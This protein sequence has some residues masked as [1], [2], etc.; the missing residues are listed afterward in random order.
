VELNLASWRAAGSISGPRG[1]QHRTA[2]CECF[3]IL[4]E[5]PNLRELVVDKRGVGCS[6][7]IIE[8]SIARK[9]S[10]IRLTWTN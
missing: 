8:D 1:K 7:R 5:M 2:V 3:V 10:K 9:S 6:R 4:G